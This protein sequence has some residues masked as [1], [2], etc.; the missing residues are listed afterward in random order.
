MMTSIITGDIVNSRTVNP[1]L[2]IAAL[3]KIFNKVGKSPKAWEIFGGDSFQLEINNPADCLLSAISI[4]ASIKAIKFLD[5]RMAIGIGEITYRSP[6][7]SESNG[8]V[9]IYSGETF[10][11]LKRLKKNLVIKTP[12]ADFNDEIN[13]MLT[14]GLLTMDKWTPASA[15]M[16]TLLLKHGKLSQE[17]LA[18]KIGKA[19]S[20]IS[21][22]QKRAHFDEIM[23]MDDFFRRR[24]QN[25]INLK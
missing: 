9:F 10:E 16:V 5:V 23:L 15:D 1:N 12:W 4:K 8:P 2:W 6:K 19:Q 3:K 7:I 22:A 11:T 24:L 17:K 18:A 14:L 13:V 25:H 21:E 20:T